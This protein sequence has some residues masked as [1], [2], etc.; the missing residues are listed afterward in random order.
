MKI[1]NITA[2][3]CNVKLI[4]LKPAY[5]AA[6]LESPLLG[7]A[8]NRKLDTLLPWGS[9]IEGLVPGPMVNTF[10]IQVANWWPAA[11][12]T[13]MTSKLPLCSHS[14]GW[15]QCHLCYVH[16]SPWQYCQFQTW[17]IPQPWQFQCWSSVSF[18]LISGS[19][20]LPK[21]KNLHQNKQPRNNICEGRTLHP[22]QIRLQ[23]CFY[24]SAW[25]WGKKKQQ[26]FSLFTLS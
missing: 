16:Q 2:Q 11:S 15:H 14:A 19:G 20:Y 25:T 21:K 4:S 8:H 17:W 10:P 1:A 13:C 7:L 5:E 3:N 24:K 18:T 12:T 26:L 9:V 22:M 23:K 6:A